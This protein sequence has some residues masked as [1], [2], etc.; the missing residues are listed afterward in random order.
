MTL[1]CRNSTYCALQVVVEITVG[2]L[3]QDT[4]LSNASIANQ[5][6]LENVIQIIFHGSRL[7]ISEAPKRRNTAIAQSTDLDLI[8]ERTKR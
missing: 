3:Q 4:G 2:K 8:K 7:Y 1:R 6:Y 5:Q